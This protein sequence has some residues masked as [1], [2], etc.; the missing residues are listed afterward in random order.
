[1]PC[2]SAM[3]TNVYTVRPDMNV[4]DAL[5]YLQTHNIRSAP[6]VDEENRMVGLFC[7]SVLLKNLLPVSV[8]M[9]EGLQKLNFLIG[10]GPGIAKRL[11][12]VKFQTVADV[13]RTDAVVLH[14]STPIWE[15]LRLVVKYGSPLPV[16]DEKDNKLLG[17]ISEQSCLDDLH[18]ILKEVEE[19]ERLEQQTQTS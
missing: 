7:L 11:R 2:D 16:V 12:K 3:V 4:A 1:M 9:E 15:V 8:T 10:A 18:N 14:V 19:E 6:V 13:M 5:E 17:I